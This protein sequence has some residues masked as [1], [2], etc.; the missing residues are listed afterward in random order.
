LIGFSILTGFGGLN[1]IDFWLPEGA[2]LVFGFLAGASD[3]PLS[4]FSTFDRFF[5]GDVFFS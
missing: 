1:S 2:F 3:F 5:V 4:V